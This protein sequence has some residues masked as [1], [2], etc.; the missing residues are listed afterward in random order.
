MKKGSDN[1]RESSLQGVVKF[2]KAKGLEAIVY[3]PLIKE[4]TFCG[5]KVVRSLRELKQ[6]SDL[7]LANRMSRDLVDVKDK[8]FTRDCLNTDK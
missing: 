5:S 3:E 7:I 1:F 8:V 2:I 4:K 6:K